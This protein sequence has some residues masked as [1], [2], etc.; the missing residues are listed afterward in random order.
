V[1]AVPRPLAADGRVDMIPLIVRPAPDADVYARLLWREGHRA[2]AKDSYNA[3]MVWAHGAG[4]REIARGKP[5]AAG[6]CGSHSPGRPRLQRAGFRAGPVRDHHGGPRK[7][8]HH[9]R[10]VPQSR[11]GGLTAVP[12]QRA[13]PHRR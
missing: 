8:H 12:H 11:V 7:R 4:R 1:T 2:I 6:T 5:G 10:Q 13:V 9:G 3:P